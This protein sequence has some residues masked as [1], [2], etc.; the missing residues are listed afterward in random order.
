MRLSTH[1]AVYLGMT[2]KVM[3][4][5]LIA[6]LASSCHRPY[7]DYEKQ[8]G[9]L[10]YEG[11][12]LRTSQGPRAEVQFLGE[13]SGA[14][15]NAKSYVPI[16][17]AYPF[18]G[19]VFPPEITAPAFLW[20]DTGA[21]AE[22]WMVA[23]GFDSSATRMYA[24]TSGKPS[25]VPLD[26][27]CIRNN[28]RWEAP[29]RHEWT[30]DSGLWRAIKEQ[31]RRGAARVDIYGVARRP[32]GKSMPVSRGRI[33][34]RTSN[35]PVGAPIFYRD[36]PL[37]PIQNTTGVIQPISENAIPLIAWRLRDI[38]RPFAPIVMNHMPT[39]VNCH[40]FSSNGGTLGM[41]MDGPQGDKGAYALVPIAKRIVVR[42]S[43]V[44]TWNKYNREKNTFGL[45]SRVS[46]DGRFVVSAVDEEV[47]VVNYMD[48]RFLQT[49]Y[50]TKSRIAYYDR[51]TK[52]IATLHGAD[53][54]A[55]VQCNPVW[56]PDG[57][58]VTF[59]RAKARPA[60]SGP[61]ATYA[62]DTLE[63]RIQYDLYQVPFNGGKGGK[64]SAILGASATGKS[65]SFP[66]YSPDGKWIVF[67]QAK[68]GLLMRPDSRLYII[69][70]GGGKA[71]ELQC[72]LPLMN[73]WHSFS[74]NGKWLVFSSKGFTP[75][76][77][78]FLTHI[79]E[80]G[81]A[82]PAILVPNSTAPNR[83]VN[84]PEFVNISPD[85]IST[86]ITPA[87]DYRVYLDKGKAFLKNGNN[88]SAYAEIMKSIA[89]KPDYAENFSRLAF[90]FAKQGKMTDAMDASLKA[91]KFDPANDQTHANA[92]MVLYALHK[93]PEAVEQFKIA[94]KY[95]SRNTS[96]HFFYALTLE[97]RNDLQEAL[98]QYNET[99]L[100]DTAHADAYSNRGTIMY[101]MNNVDQALSDFTKAIESPFPKAEYYQNRAVAY[102]AKKE[103][104]KA[105]ADLSVAANMSPD[106][107]MTYN[108]RGNV[109]LQLN[110]LDKALADFEAAIKS[111]Q[112][113]VKAIE[114]LCDIC[115]STNK[116]AEAL[117]Y[118]NKLIDLDPRNPLLIKR[119]AVAYMYTGEAAKAIEDF[120]F[121][122]ST[123]FSEPTIHFNK[124]MCYE[125]LGD[126]DGAMRNYSL[127]LKSGARQ[128]EQFEFAGK[129]IAELKR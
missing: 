115:F 53:D 15:N 11:A 98:L 129:R 102:A 39:C 36:V 117:P 106:D 87:V 97:A 114:P 5:F 78:M 100:L 4:L 34:L 84:I 51:E 47:H 113:C 108:I 121:V 48:F 44:F 8:N 82:G 60:F 116:H 10:I 66:K 19:S 127:F 94:L 61:K 80:N 14:I 119:R 55:Y 41:D 85:G 54:S 64:P 38:G 29:K 30:P 107:G 96:T 77:Q 18:E 40:S 28:N 25:A 63:T 2:E 81:D 32:D 27:E 111:K 3:T 71:R 17:I 57:K 72:N 76:T 104:D 118:I 33:T 75:F 23:I 1:C 6:I 58:L 16:E 35:D 103:F 105:L 112:T 74:P 7:Y 59:L 45:F 46:P 124:A 21:G 91:V 26:S 125:K 110:I 120:D 90:V 95:N 68:N 86:I 12:V 79:D 20:N 83:A 67:V 123:T 99:L 92:G 109:Y 31:S 128:S 65:V 49:F 43:D 13:I 89:L 22:T 126:L 9:C 56:S 24:L 62:N 37:M 50:P 93:F 122:L 101:G 69:S 73:S 70:A 88:D 42:Q 52:K